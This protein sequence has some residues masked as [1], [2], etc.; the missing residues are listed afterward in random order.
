MELFYKLFLA[1]DK[2]ARKN[3][4]AGITSAWI[5]SGLRLCVALHDCARDN[6]LMLV[7]LFYC[8]L[9]SFIQS[10]MKSDG[11]NTQSQQACRVNVWGLLWCSF[12]SIFS[13]A[14]RSD[15]TTVLD[16][17]KITNPANR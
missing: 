16:Q 3:T 1:Q 12:V 9:L 15:R 6:R 10:S 7:M 5:R 4:F 2:S 11:E 14:G 13:M 8:T 17:G